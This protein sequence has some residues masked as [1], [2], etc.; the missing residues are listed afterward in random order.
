MVLKAFD[1][2]SALLELGYLSSEH[3]LARL[4]SAEWRERAADSTAQAIDRYFAERGAP[5]TEPAQEVAASARP[6]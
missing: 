5:K 4:T 1:T 2:P 6:Q 3:D